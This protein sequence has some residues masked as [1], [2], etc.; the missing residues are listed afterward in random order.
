MNIDLL[1]KDAKSEGK[2]EGY[3]TAAREYE[4][5]Y[6]EQKTQNRK[7]KE[8][9]EQAKGKH[10]SE[11]RTLISHQKELENYKAELER[12]KCDLADRVARKHN[13]N[14]TAAMALAS[15]GSFVAVEIWALIPLVGTVMILKEKQFK[16]GFES[17]YA[18]A[19]KLYLEKLRK[20]Q[21]ELR[22]LK[23]EGDTQINSLIDMIS[24]I[25]NEIA[26]LNLEIAE[27]QNSL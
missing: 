20:L 1:F 2:K 14:A 8:Y 4:K 18:E 13:I 3:N 11:A 17:G 23:S 19:R 6:Q 25:K 21:D 27:L 15:S 10:V 24:S 26:K 7:T 9:I 12:K 22:Q 16:S 5:V